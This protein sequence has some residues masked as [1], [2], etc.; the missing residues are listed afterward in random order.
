MPVVQIT[1]LRG[2]TTEQKRNIAK[3]VTEVLA[4]E[5]GANPAAVVITFVDV[6]RDSY[7]S[8]GVLISDKH[9]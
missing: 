2:R 1:L 4:E 6:D 3:R 5:G 8:G 9:S 7:S